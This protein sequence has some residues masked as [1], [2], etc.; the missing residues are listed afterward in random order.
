M[1]RAEHA[2]LLQRLHPLPAAALGRGRSRQG[3][4][5][6]RAG[7]AGAG[8]HR[9]LAAHASSPAAPA[10]R[11]RSTA[12]RR[13]RSRP[14]RTG[15]AQAAPGRQ[16]PRLGLLRR[17]HRRAQRA[18][19]GRR[20]ALR[21]AAPEPGPRRPATGTTFSEDPRLQLAPRAPPAWRPC[22][23]RA[24]SAPSRRSATTTPTSRT[25]PRATTTRSA[26]SQVGFRTGWLGRYLDLGR[27]RR[28]P[29]AGP[30]DGRLALADDR[31]RREAGG[32]DRQRRRLR[33]LVAGR[34]TRSSDEMFRSF[35]RFGS[36]PSDS[37][38][39]AQVRRADR[40]DRQAAPGPRRRRR[41]HQPGRLSRNL[42]R[43][44][45]RRP[46]RLSSPPA[47]RCG[48]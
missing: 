9:A 3:P 41:L 19:P 36:L 44:Q 22:T 15:I 26:S 27:R 25:S 21:A 48:W 2:Q 32:G 39:L 29:A 34:A 31:H 8:R 43:P 40:P 38:G 33:P 10:W 28:E 42:L 46:R 1:S 37:P 16:D 17:R 47:C 12:P 23:P 45:A 24:R 4:A 18:G 7:D 30:L 11:W 5:G 20:P 14:S 6:D 35:A 13:S